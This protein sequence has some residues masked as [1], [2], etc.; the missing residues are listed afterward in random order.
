M[1]S[2]PK[3]LENGTEFPREAEIEPR[4]TQNLEMSDVQ[5]AV[6]SRRVFS[7]EQHGD[8]VRTISEARAYA[9]QFQE[10]WLHRSNGSP[11][12]FVEYDKS[13]K[14][15]IFRPNP[16]FYPSKAWEALVAYE[17]ESI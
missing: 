3:Y 11:Q 1:P 12:I 2:S 4:E 15:Y 7:A 6:R 17:K 16:D 14:G 10:G 13:E 8:L 9:N 5:Q